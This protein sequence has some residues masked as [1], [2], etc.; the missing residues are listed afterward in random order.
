[1][2]VH[3]IVNGERAHVDVE[4][5]RT[6]ADA[7]RED[8][9]LTGTHLGCEHGV[10]GACTVLVD[11]APARAC[12]MF[13]VQADGAEVTT[14]EGLQDG[15][16]ALHPLQ[17]AF[18]AHHGL[19]CGFCTPG[20]LMTAAHLLDTH[21]GADRETIRAEMAGNICRCTGYQGIVDA[22]EAAGN[23]RDTPA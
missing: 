9:G 14:V 19:Q 3:L 20:M 22:V 4:P 16:G 5:R 7:L 11:G 15:D 1:M 18:V 23:A 12:L 6:L 2:D 21:P 8:L 17:E 10:C 13:A